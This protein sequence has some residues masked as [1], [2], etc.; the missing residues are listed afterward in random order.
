[1]VRTGRDR[2]PFDRL[3][4]E[5]EMNSGG[6]GGAKGRRMEVGGRTRTL[7]RRASRCTF[8]IPHL[9]EGTSCFPPAAAVSRDPGNAWRRRHGS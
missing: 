5:M 2:S 9:L 3:R 8:V 6:V 1:M 4:D 7:G